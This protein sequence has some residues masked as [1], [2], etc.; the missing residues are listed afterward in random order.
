M[1][2][3]FSEV[4]HGECILIPGSVVVMERLE[5]TAGLSE[6]MDDHVKWIGST[7][8]DEGFVRRICALFASLL[9]IPQLS[10]LSSVSYTCRA[11]REDRSLGYRRQHFVRSRQQFVVQHCL[12]WCHS[13]GTVVR[14]LPHLT[15]R[16]NPRQVL[17][18]HESM[19]LTLT[20]FL[21]HASYW[22]IAPNGHRGRESNHFYAPHRSTP[23]D[24]VPRLAVI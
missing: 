14:K 23:A 5:K 17:V 2:I 24:R 22:C 6:Y 1:K 12:C 7:F 10:I 21:L 11:H 3:V 9:T 15:Q 16:T 19:L 20:V 13:M 4:K 18:P 8:A